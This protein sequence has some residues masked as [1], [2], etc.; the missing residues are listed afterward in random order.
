MAKLRTALSDIFHSMCPNVYFQP[1]TGTKIK[2]PC[3]I[4]E[5]E[6][7][8][9]RHADNVP[10][11]LYDLYNIKYITRDPDDPVRNQLVMLPLC[12]SEN[13]YVSDN[14]HHYPFY[15]YW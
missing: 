12:S 1:P 13:S 10:Y 15:I 6:R 9:V 11:A 4:Y 5:L 14:L 7:T 8:N 2:Y 3:I